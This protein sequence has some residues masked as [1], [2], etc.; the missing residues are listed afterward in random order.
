MDLTP[1]LQLPASIIFRNS[2][3]ALDVVAVGDC[4]SV[5]ITLLIPPAALSPRF[6]PLMT[7][8][9][10]TDELIPID[11]ATAIRML[12]LLS[13]PVTQQRRLGFTS[14]HR[15]AYNAFFVYHYSIYDELEVD[16]FE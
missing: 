2:R 6:D 14:L 1:I 11:A 8:A 4:D 9:T 16:R 10:P 15:S 5:D 13:K 7:V 12:Q 3:S